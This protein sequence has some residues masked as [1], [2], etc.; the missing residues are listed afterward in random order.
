MRGLHLN[1]LLAQFFSSLYAFFPI[2]KAILQDQFI[3][4][5]KLIQKNSI[6]AQPWADS[7]FFFSFSV[8]SFAFYYKCNTLYLLLFHELISMIVGIAYIVSKIYFMQSP[9]NC[10]QG[11]I[12]RL[13]NSCL[14]YKSPESAILLCVMKQLCYFYTC[15]SKFL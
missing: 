8:F 5:G 10:G 1:S 7:Y 2:L 11:L 13:F 9:S 12:A 6:L 3:K 14:Q 15:Y 4:L